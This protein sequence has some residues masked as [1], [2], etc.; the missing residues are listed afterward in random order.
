MIKGKRS[1]I[2]PNVHD[3]HDQP[4]EDDVSEQNTT[5]RSKTSQKVRDAHFLEP[6]VKADGTTGSKHFDADGNEVKEAE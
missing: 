1:K 5:G 2:M 3:R 4:T 6:G